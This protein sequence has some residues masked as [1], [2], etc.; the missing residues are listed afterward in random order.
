MYKEYTGDS[1]E[2]QQYIDECISKEK[3]ETEKEIYENEID[4]IGGIDLIDLRLIR[5]DVVHFTNYPDDDRSCHLLQL[6][7]LHLWRLNDK[8]K[9]E[10][11]DFVFRIVTHDKNYK[12]ST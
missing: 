8:E 11:I 1:L 4:V 9:D 7:G 6:I 5:D 10:I 3:Y 12:E 2:E